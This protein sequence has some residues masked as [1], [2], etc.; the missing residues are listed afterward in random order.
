[1][2]AS[3]ILLLAMLGGWYSSHHASPA[4]ASEESGPHEFQATG[5]T[6]PVQL[7]PRQNGVVR[8]SFDLLPTTMSFDLPSFPCLVTEN[9]IKYSNFWA[10]TYDPRQ[11]RGEGGLASFE[12]LMDRKNRYAR[13]WIEHKSNARIVVR[14]RG[15][16]CNAEGDIAHTDFPSKSPYGP[17]DWVDEWYTIYPDG[18]HARHVKVYTGLAPRSRPFGIAHD[19][20][21][22]NHEF[23]EAA[24]IG[25]EGTLPTDNIETEALT[26]VRLNRGHPSDW[27]AE[28][29]SGTISYKPYPT[30]FGDLR[31]ANIML[32][33]LKSEYKPF[34][35]GM[36]YGVRVSPYMSRD[37]LPHVFQTWGNTSAL[38]H[39][40]NYWHHR[41]TDNT[42]EQIYLQGMTNAE[43][44]VEYLVDLAWSWIADPV[45]YMKGESRDYSYDLR[46]DHAQRAYIIPR[47]G[48]GPTKLEFAL[49]ENADIVD[50]GAE[51]WIFNPCFVVKDWGET[52][53]KLKV[54][55]K[56]VQPGTGFRV[57]HEKNNTGTDL[58]LWLKLK[59][60]A[61]VEFEIAPQSG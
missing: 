23:Q 32:V 8:V 12:P 60:R 54:N 4:V 7:A 16:L 51:S 45:L 20:P 30:D 49:E 59:T 18:V 38:A 50:F 27:V 56:A 29:I 28:G 43:E 52:G 36:P 19:P 41:R 3:V 58:V 5:P 26:L 46:Y 48:R 10:E 24:V 1:M 44:P 9:G 2:K 55:G 42:L 37:P 47:E 35:I 22:V 40:I 6:E 11:W 33:N 25:K 57:G 53:A 17:G 21:K 31:D 15:A 34:T 14:V 61:T 13:M 39:M